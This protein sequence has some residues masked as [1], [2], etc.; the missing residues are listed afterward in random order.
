[1]EMPCLNFGVSVPDSP[2]CMGATVTHGGPLQHTLRDVTF[3]RLRMAQPAARIDI[4]Y[5]G[6]W[7]SPDRF[8]A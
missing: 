4:G 5:F 3:R 2:T 1:M 7:V 8:E 6:G